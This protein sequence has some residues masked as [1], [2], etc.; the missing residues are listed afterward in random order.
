MPAY[1]RYGLIAGAAIAGANLILQFAVTPF[2][3]WALIGTASVGVWLIGVIAA[4]VRCSTPRAGAAAGA[5]AASVDVARGVA[6]TLIAGPHI[7]SGTPVHEI[8]SG[9]IVSAGVVELAL[10]APVAACVGYAA[11]RFAGRRPDAI[12]ES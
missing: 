4:G 2:A 8:T 7:P 12:A 9:M 6:A 1:A 11:A 10:I 3:P 5:V